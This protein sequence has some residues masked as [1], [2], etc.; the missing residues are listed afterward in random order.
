MKS[1]ILRTSADLKNM[2]DKLTKHFN[3]KSYESLVC[4]VDKYYKAETNGQLR[5]YYRLIDVVKYWMNEQGNNYTKE[6]VDMYFRLKSEHYNII[7]GEKITK[8]ISLKSGTTK[9]DM[10]RLIDTVLDFGIEFNIADCELTN[11]ELLSILR[12]YKD[13]EVEKAS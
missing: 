7:K 3:R 8:S 4:Q 13:N 5:G 1:Y 12:D 9:Q 6:E 10:K 2:I 11:E